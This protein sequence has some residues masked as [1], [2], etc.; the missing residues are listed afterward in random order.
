LISESPENI[1]AQLL[2]DVNSRNMFSKNN[3]VGQQIIIDSNNNFVVQKVDNKQAWIEYKTKDL[4]TNPIINEDYLTIRKYAVITITKDEQQIPILI[5]LEK[6]NYEVRSFNS[7]PTFKAVLD[8]CKSDQE[9]FK[10]IAPYI[11]S[12]VYDYNTAAAYGKQAYNWLCA[13]YYDLKPEQINPNIAQL[14]DAL[15]NHLENRLNEHEC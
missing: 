8:I 5:R 13:N 10:N 11:H 6:G 7:Y 4:G 14:V 2:N 15:N 12:L 1:V 9:L 3:W